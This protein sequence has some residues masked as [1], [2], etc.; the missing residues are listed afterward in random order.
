M[1]GQS[2]LIVHAG[3]FSAMSVLDELERIAPV[4]AVHG[5]VDEPA[6]VTRLPAR[7]TVDA[8]GLRIGLVHDPGPVAGRRDRLRSCFGGC[9]AIVYGHTHAPVVEQ[10]DGVW[11]LNPGSPTERRRAPAHTMI[12]VRDGWPELVGL[13]A[14]GRPA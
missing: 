8:E 5:N 10:V 7:T 1:L 14:A 9:D 12:V 13:T 4:S 2:S 6:L 3:D 11:F